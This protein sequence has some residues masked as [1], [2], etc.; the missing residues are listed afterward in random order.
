[1]S[2]WSWAWIAACAIVASACDS[3]LIVDCAPGRFARVDGTPWC[4][5]D[6][7]A[8]TRCPSPLPVEHD[9][10]GGARACAATRHD[11]APVVLCVI[12]GECAGDAGS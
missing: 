9:L 6:D 2:R 8:T 7:R 11:P 1:M 5:Y 4:V 10:A 3:P 12:A